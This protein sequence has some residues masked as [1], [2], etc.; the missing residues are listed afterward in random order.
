[1]R[2][3][4]QTLFPVRP[5]SEP[6]DRLASYLHEV[7]DSSIGISNAVR[8]G[9][10]VLIKPN[11]NS[12]DP[13][14]NSTDLGLLI[15]LIRLL[16]DHGAGSVVVGEGSRH[17]PTDTRYELR[18]AGVFEACKR[19]GASVE[20]FGESGWVPRRT[21]GERLR[22][23]EVAKPLLE[24][25]RLVFACCLKTHW[26]TN[27]SISL[28]HTVGCVRPR[29]RARM[30]FGGHIEE[31][32]AEIASAFRPDLVIVD[33]RQCYFRG[34]PCYGFVRGA[35]VILAGADR[36]AIDVTGIRSLESVPGCSLKCDPWQ[37]QQ[38][39]QAVTLGLGARCDD[40][41]DLRER[42]LGVY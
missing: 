18:R 9:D 36:V 42:R 31:Q 37:S 15:A 23:V 4:L 34:G 41:I 27:Y 14:P 11:F 26:L 1:L 21:L 2:T 35:G 22:W 12:G 28:K 20:V 24:C 25:D 5:A 13:P 7:I 29:H 32:I 10:H 6:P 38:I 40:E 8:P 39:R 17:P 16:R 33:G 30:H 19:A 3:P